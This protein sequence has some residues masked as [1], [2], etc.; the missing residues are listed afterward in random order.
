MAFADILYEAADGVAT[1]TF[2]RPEKLNAARPQTHEEFTAALDQADHDD[3]VRA[4]IV[5]GS[6]RAFCSGTDLS[7]VNWSGRGGDPATGE[8]VPPDVAAP[9]P[10]R[11]WDMN[12][13]VIGAIN[14]VAVGFGASV[15]CSMD[16]RLAAEGARLAFIYTRRG[17]C[18]ESCSSFFLPR[19]VGI[20][21]A[22]DWVAT[23][24]M[25]AAEE[26]KSS[27]FVRE[28]L[29]AE[30][31]LPAARAL[32]R[33]IADHTSP[34][35]VAVSR[36]LMWNMLAAS[37]PLE[38]TRMEARAL[39]GLMRLA[40]ARE[41]PAAFKEKRAPRFSTRPSRELDFMRAWWP[42]PQE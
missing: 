34:A 26:L 8:G 28:V 12:K 36:K 25:I 23:G 4:V 29:P 11:I 6:G 42:A 2:N 16:I 3:A 1:I 41:G 13:P 40:D 27:G 39:T 5:T 24:R 15:L 37:H 18:N 20:A 38:A 32:A 30:S 31:L 14:G 22:M 35:A 19:A 7:G 33:E 10:L 9:G 21:R 17:V